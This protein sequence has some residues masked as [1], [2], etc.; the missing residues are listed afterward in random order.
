MWHYP[1][2]SFVPDPRPPNPAQL[3]RDLC[4]AIDKGQGDRARELL[5]RAFWH[6]VDFKPDAFHLLMAAQRGDRALVTLLT[7]YGAGWTV[8]EAKTARTLIAPD[9]WAQVRGPLKNAGIRTEFTAEELAQKDVFTAIAFAHR[10]LADAKAR[11][12][13]GMEYTARKLQQA[14]STGFTA[15]VIAG[16]VDEAKRL[17]PYRSP[18]LGTGTAE[19]PLEVSGE[20]EELFRKDPFGT[21]HGILF[22]DRLQA[23]GVKVKP[24]QVTPS[25]M[26]LKPQVVLELEARGLLAQN[27]VAARREL[28]DSLTSLQQRIALGGRVFDM[29]PENFV[30]R[31]KQLTAIAQVLFP[32]EKPVTEREAEQ[33]IRLHQS[34]SRDI[35]QGIRTAENALLALGFFDGAVWNA[36]RLQ[37]MLAAAPV[38]DPKLSTEFNKRAL[39][40]VIE[41]TGVDKLLRKGHVVQLIEAHHYGAYVGDAESTAKIIRA[42]AKEARVNPPEAINDALKILQKAGADFRNVDPM[43]YL[44]KREPGFAKQLL[45]LGIVEAANFDVRG[46]SRR[47]GGKLSILSFPH[48]RRHEYTGFVCQLVLE[49][50]NP[51]KFIPL[52]GANTGEYQQLFLQEWLKNNGSQR[53]SS[54]SYRRK[55]PGL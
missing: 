24:L 11:G 44:G 3:A 48:A 12:M 36:E 43:E 40:R 45:D 54:F 6:K 13:D 30:R 4:E 8:E 14:V 10:S 5:D 17:L 21:R 23:A 22:L 55:M 46:V 50:T 29:G 47:Q 27:Q 35:P 37:R 41:E 42:L 31:E 32:K 25:M 53:I 2:D 18:V 15:L 7:G 9:K 49:L 34:R 28:L 39:R 16:K 38:T 19:D 33:F 52:R 1:P 26:F 51:E 20:I